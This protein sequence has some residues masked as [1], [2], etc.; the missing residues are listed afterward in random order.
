MGDMTTFRAT[1][2]VGAGAAGGDGAGAA[3][4]DGGTAAPAAVRRPADR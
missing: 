2:R 3:G 1:G 4:G